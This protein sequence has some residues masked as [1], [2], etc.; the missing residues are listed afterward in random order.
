M[1]PLSAPSQSTDSPAPV[2]GKGEPDFNEHEAAAILW[3][4]QHLGVGAVQTGNAVEVLGEPNL[5]LVFD[6]EWDD[7]AK[8]DVC[9]FTAYSEREGAETLRSR[10]YYIGFQTRAGTRADSGN[11]RCWDIIRPRA[12]LLTTLDW[13]ILRG[14]CARPA[15]PTAS[16]YRWGLSDRRLL[17]EQYRVQAPMPIEPRHGLDC[18]TNP[19]SDPETLARI[20]QDALLHPHV[21]AATPKQCSPIVRWDS[22]RSQY[23]PLELMNLRRVNGIEVFTPFS[24]PLERYIGSLFFPVSSLRETDWMFIAAPVSGYEIA[25]ASTEAY[26]RLLSALHPNLRKQLKEE[27]CRL[28]ALFQLNTGAMTIADGFKF[29]SLVYILENL[30]TALSRTDWNLPYSFDCQGIREDLRRLF[31]PYQSPW[32]PEQRMQFNLDRMKRSRLHVS[33]KLPC[34]TGE[35]RPIGYQTVELRSNFPSADY[36][37]EIG[38]LGGPRPA[39]SLGYIPLGPWGTGF[40]IHNPSFKA[41]KAINNELDQQVQKIFNP[42]GEPKSLAKIAEIKS[43]PLYRNAEWRYH[44]MTA[45]G[46]KPN[47]TRDN[48]RW[49]EYLSIADYSDPDFL[50]AL[51]TFIRENKSNEAG[52]YVAL[53]LSLNNPWTLY[54]LELSLDKTFPLGAAFPNVKERAL[55]KLWFEKQDEAEREARR[56]KGSPRTVRRAVQAAQQRIDEAFDRVEAIHYLP[57]GSWQVIP[58]KSR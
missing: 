58:P 9:L 34:W 32:S 44:V 49:E 40:S 47:T 36:L 54:R 2:V 11:G 43:H 48:K 22:W 45:I 13:A 8:K 1:T 46:A 12:G 31:E 14:I 57:A 25:D 41:F 30:K 53:R 51:K 10:A 17:I 56:A 4:R 27:I 37:R 21:E 55:M 42:D 28:A 52:W 24:R 16:L 15:Q 18:R 29:N 7:K 35:P 23:G 5:H 26:A 6:W 39:R 20:V 3:R 33:G 50:L 38:E 19:I